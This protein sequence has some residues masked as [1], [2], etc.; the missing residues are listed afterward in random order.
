MFISGYLAKDARGIASQINEVLS[1]PKYADA[2][3]GISHIVFALDN[4]SKT[5][6][7]S[8]IARIHD[9]CATLDDHPEI[10]SALQHLSRNIEREVPP[11]GKT[12]RRR[13]QVQR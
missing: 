12:R 1:A 8:A 7:Q 4:P 9:L 6:L 11:V 2:R 10:A 3:E 13:L 5:K